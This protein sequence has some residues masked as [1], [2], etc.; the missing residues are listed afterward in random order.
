MFLLAVGA[1]VLT[2]NLASNAGNTRALITQK[3]DDHQLATLTGNTRPEVTALS[4]RGPVSAD[5]QLNHMLLL[6]QRS[7]EQEK[8][9]EQFIEDQHNPNSPLFHQWIHSAEFGQRFGLAQS[10]IDKITNWLESYGLKVEHVYQNRMLIDYSGT[11]SQ[12]GNAFHMELH[13]YL[14]NG[15]LRMANDRDPQIPTALA[16]AVVGPLYLNNFRPKAMHEQLHGAHISPATGTMHPDYTAGGGLPLVPFDLEKIYNITPLFSAGITGQG[17]TVMV[18]E[19]TNQWNCNSTNSLGPCSTTTSDFAV[20][21]NTFGLGRWPSGNLSQTN[22]GTTTTNHCSAPSTGRG[23]PAGSGINTDDVE[24]TIDVEWATAAA[25]NAN[26]VS[27]ACANPSG[28]FGGLTAIQNTLNHPNQDGVDVISMSYGESEESTGASLNAAFNT[29]FQQLVTAGIGMFVSSGDEDAAS[30]GVRDGITISGWMS[31]PNDVSVGGLDFAD[32]YLGLNSTYWNTTNNVFYGSAKSYIMEQPWNDSCAGTLLAEFLTGSYITYGSTGF[33]NTTTGANYHNG[34][35]GSGGPSACAT[36][37]PA[38]A[39]VA[40][41]TCAGYAKPSYQSNYLGSMAGL[42]NDNVRDTPDVSLMAANG[43]WGHYYLVCYS[44]TTSGGLGN[45]GTPCTGQPI[46]WPGYGGTS[47]SSPI[48]ASIQ[49]LV[50][51]HKGSRQGNPNF[52][53]YALAATEY[54]P[55][56]SAACNSTR[57]AAVGLACIFYDVTL[58]DNDAYCIANRNGNYYNCYRPSGADGVQ[59]TSNNSY[60]P[61][62]PTGPGQPFTGNGPGWDFA[63]GIGSVNAYNLVM[64]Y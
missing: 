8:E 5:L 54:G 58:G 37:A 22:P 9:L 32:T 14:V 31:S 62:Y 21:R 2:L 3:I 18:V 25:P 20:F 23:Y 47:V 53:Y 51:Q 33:C 10:D 15:E 57:G 50:V 48:M 52:R 26:I 4:D 19:D 6:L 35:G 28:G 36:G 34:T 38:V 29:T 56:G 45:G 44:D 41:G 55:G 11:A 17:T 13:N 39:G 40:S 46:N 27:A 16:K 24:A 12:I 7:P 49:D 59:S 43:L 1:L 60:L 42:V 63:S 61:A 30:S 64:A